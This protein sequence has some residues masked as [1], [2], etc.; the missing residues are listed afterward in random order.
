M[1]E[2][3]LRNAK[4]GPRPL[5]NRRERRK[6][7]TRQTLLD[8]TQALLAKRSFDALS[9]DDIVERADVARGT[10]YN[11]FAD[12]D[13]L[14]RELASQSR[15]RIEGEIA[16]VNKGV[17]RS[18]GTN[19]TRIPERATAR[20]Q[21]TA[22]VNRNDAAFPASDRSCGAHQFRGPA[23]CRARH[24]SRPDRR[25]LRGCRGRLRNGC[26]HGRIEPRA[27][28][29][30]RPCTRIRTGTWHNSAAWAWPQTRGGGAHHA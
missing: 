6:L 22:A 21:R 24:D 28:P 25:N 12:K 16:R 27:R 26:F 17:I 13:A 20:H 30:C 4:P 19:R 5:S 23:R 7:A 11:Y 29:A 2:G 3:Q 10:F 18:G 15:A 14:E 1:K 8:A 9:V